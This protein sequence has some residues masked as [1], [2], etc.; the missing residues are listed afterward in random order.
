VTVIKHTPPGRPFLQAGLALA[1]GSVAGWYASPGVRV[2]GLLVLVLGAVHASRAPRRGLGAGWL[3]LIGLCAAVRCGLLHALPSDAPSPYKVLVGRAGLPCPTAGVWRSLVAHLLWEQGVEGS[4]PFTPTTAHRKEGTGASGRWVSS[5]RV[6]PLQGQSQRGNLGHPEDRLECLL[7][8]V[9]SGER[10]RLLG[11]GTPLRGA[12]LPGTEPPVIRVTLGVDELARTAPALLKIEIPGAASLA[13]LRKSILVRLLAAEDSLDPKDSVRGLLPALIVGER[14]GL[15]ATTRD[16]FTRTGTRHLLALSGLHVSL[17]A[18]WIIWPLGG[19]LARALAQVTGRAGGRRPQPWLGPDPLRALL[20]LALV[21]LAGGGAP[22]WRAAIALA[23]AAV[24]TCLPA[25]AATGEVPCH[26]R[27]VDGLSLWGL[28]LCLELLLSP[29]S[30]GHLGLQLSYLATLG[31][32]LG[33]PAVGTSC[34]LRLKD[35]DALGRARSPWWRIPAQRALDGI[36]L[37][38]ATSILAVVVTLPIIWVRFGQI[39]PVGIV[40]TP[41]AMLPMMGLLATGWLHT[42]AP[43]IL[44][45]EVVHLPGRAL[46]ALLEACDQLPATPWP[47]PERPWPWIVLLTGIAFLGMTRFRRA[48]RPKALTLGAALA[49]GGFLACSSDADVNTPPE[50]VVLDVGH[51]T[52]AMLRVPGEDVWL[53]DAGSRD[54][55]GVAAC[56][57]EQLRRWQTRDLSV[58]VSHRD[59]DHSS[60]LPWIVERWPPRVAAGAME[61]TPGWKGRAIDLIRGRLQLPTRGDLQLFLL[62]GS[63]APGN[64]GS[65]CLEIRWGSWRAL[66]TGDAEQ[67]GLAGLLEPGILDGPYDLVL[68]PHHGSESPHLDEFLRRCRPTEIWISCGSPAAL[69]PELDRQGRL[70]SSTYRSGALVARP[71]RERLHPPQAP[72]L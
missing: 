31:L 32:L 18:W 2:A 22:I 56:V 43:G 48:G 69:G 19:W 67:D 29:E 24:A 13:L 70:W 30:I 34:P 58:V 50:L 63:D 68:L 65:R 17:L 21:P 8:S 38:V 62:R 57:G 45:L 59:R 20:L 26:G 49:L 1:S 36:W 39:A 55:I 46:I 35:T 61:G 54:R 10:V 64:E 51:G 72:P 37:G 4:N 27:R 9:S 60:A 3:L 5:D 11:S 47:L 6:R 52:A 44:P 33:L 66:L 28:A 25:S 40:A 14:T 16:L 15:S 71:G 23:L 7:N 53:F 42:C 41:L 12:A